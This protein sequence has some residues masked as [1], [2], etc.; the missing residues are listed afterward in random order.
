MTA[1]DET[2][3]RRDDRRETGRVGR[4]ASIVL[5]LTTN[6]RRIL[7]SEWGLGERLPLPGALKSVSKEAVGEAGLPNE[8][9][10]VGLSRLSSWSAWNWSWLERHYNVDDM[11]LEHLPTGRSRLRAFLPSS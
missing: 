10:A 6:R 11:H 7:E 5:S 3:P 2:T 1:Y 9:V 4:P 8:S